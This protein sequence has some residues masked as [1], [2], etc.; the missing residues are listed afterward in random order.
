MS[1]QVMCTCM[2]L[3]HFLCIVLSYSIVPENPSLAYMTIA[4]T[5][6]DVM[7]CAVYHLSIHQIK[8]MGMKNVHLLEILTSKCA[9]CQ[10]MSADNLPK[11]AKAH[12]DSSGKAC[13]L[14]KFVG[15]RFRRT[16][17]VLKSIYTLNS[18]DLN[19]SW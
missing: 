15:C 2:H 14:G 12:T 9:V 19:K 8:D 1:E 4:G 13:C 17:L 18:E 5:V 7:K 11:P 10:P 3:G 16:C 6:M